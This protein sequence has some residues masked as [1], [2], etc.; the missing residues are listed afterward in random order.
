MQCVVVALLQSHFETLA[1]TKIKKKKQVDGMKPELLIKRHAG[2]L[3][4]SACVQAYPYDVPEFIPQILM[5]LSNHLDDP[6][7]IQ[8]ICHTVSAQDTIYEKTKWQ[9][10]C[11]FACFEKNSCASSS[12]LIEID[13]DIL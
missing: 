12:L 3:G 10:A 5:D 4:L 6:Q 2:V 11:H 13:T 1:S 9:L 7:P 8:V